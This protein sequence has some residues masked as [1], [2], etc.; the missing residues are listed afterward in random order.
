MKITLHGHIVIDPD[1][2]V[3]DST[4]GFDAADPTAN[5]LPGSTVTCMA[6]I[7]EWGGWVPW[8]AHL[9]LNQVNPQVVGANG[10]FSSIFLTNHLARPSHRQGWAWPLHHTEKTVRASVNRLEKYGLPM[11]TDLTIPPD[12][13][14]CTNWLLPA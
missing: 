11:L 3:F 6:N 12:E 8:P 7:P 2:Y 10:Y 13:G 5:V 9:Y 4:L 1:G 14:A